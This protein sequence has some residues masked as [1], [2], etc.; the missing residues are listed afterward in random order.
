MPLAAAVEKLN[1]VLTAGAIR[2]RLGENPEALDRLRSPD[3]VFNLAREMGGLDDAELAYLT[4]IPM[5][6]VHGIRGAVAQAASQG[7]SVHFQYSPG[8]DFSVQMW[9]YGAALSVHVSG[10]YPPDYPRNNYRR[11]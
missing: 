2:E 3:E 4:D 11:P 6:L 5:A 10:P 7:Q 8:Y 1:G 9:D